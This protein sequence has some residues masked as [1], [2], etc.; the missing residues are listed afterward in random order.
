MNHGEP[1]IGARSISYRVSHSLDPKISEANPESWGTSILGESV[2]EVTERNAWG[3]NRRANYQ[4]GPYPYNNDYPTQI[5]SERSN[6]AAK[7]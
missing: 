1:G 7:M 2:A 3:R 6:R 5:C 4:G